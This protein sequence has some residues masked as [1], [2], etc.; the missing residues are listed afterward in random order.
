VELDEWKPSQLRV[1]EVGGKVRWECFVLVVR[2]IE[3]WW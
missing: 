1:M 2:A 3:G